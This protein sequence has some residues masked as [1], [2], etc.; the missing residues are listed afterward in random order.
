MSERMLAGRCLCGRVSYRVKGEPIG[1]GHC[2]CRTCQRLTGTGH[3]T[4]ALFPESSFEI[5]GTLSE[6]SFE[7][8]PGV[9]DRK[10]FCPNCGSSMFARN[11][12]ASHLLSLTLGTLDD[13]NALRPQ[14]GIYVK[15]KPAWDVLDDGLRNLD[16]SAMGHVRLTA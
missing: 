9:V 11:G 16:G 5:S 2:Y 10:M 4:G 1:V 15:Q 13:V 3:S 8:S 7:S 12:A 14:L 6:Y